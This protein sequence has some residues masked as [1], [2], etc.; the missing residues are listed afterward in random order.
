MKDAPQPSFSEQRA[1]EHA[2][3]IKVDYVLAL[4]ALKPFAEKHEVQR[5]DQILASVGLV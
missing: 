3:R 1:R 4:K 2:Q 5:I